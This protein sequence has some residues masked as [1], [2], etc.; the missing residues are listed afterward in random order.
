MTKLHIGIIEDELLIAEEIYLTLQQIGYTPL[1]PAY[2]FNDGLAMIKS[3]QPDL[4]LIDISLNDTKDGIELAAEVNNNFNIPFIFLTGNTDAETIERAKAVKPS[5]YLVKPFVHSDLFSAIEIAFSNFIS[6]QS[7]K[8]ST[9]SV[10]QALSD[11]LFIREAGIYHKIKLSEILYVE[12]D[13]VHLNIYVKDKRHITR[14][15]MDD[16]LC[17][18]AHSSFFRIHRSYA[19]NLQKL[20]SISVANVIIAGKEVPMSKVFKDDLMKVLKTLK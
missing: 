20:E 14:M 16:F 8:V 4:L 5:A 3:G 10:S 15:K 1:R 18:Y 6:H 19:I 7:E 13:N 11:S 2:N 12:S 17:D 9:K